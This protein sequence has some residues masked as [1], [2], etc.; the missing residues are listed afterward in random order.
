MNKNILSN[1]SAVSIVSMQRYYHFIVFG[2]CRRSFC[3]AALFSLLPNTRLIACVHVHARVL[4]IQRCSSF[5]H[6]SPTPSFPAASSSPASTHS[7][8]TS[9]CAAADMKSS[10]AI[11]PPA[12]LHPQLFCPDDSRLK[13]KW[14]L[15]DVL[16]HTAWPSAARTA[17]SIW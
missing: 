3:I 13:L 11:I 1:V 15:I 12:D 16:H 9:C 17:A 14:E 10:E 4:L 8:F 7:P 6:P 2:K 5:Q